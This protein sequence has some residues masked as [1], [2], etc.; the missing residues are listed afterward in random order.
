[1]CALATVLLA[2]STAV[3]QTNADPIARCRDAHV[4][5]P[6]GHIECLEEAL[7]GRGASP[8]TRA[9]PSA[10][11]DGAAIP[12]TIPTAPAP[13]A[14]TAAR[15]Q[16]IPTGLG[17]EQVPA[18]QPAPASPAEQVATVRISSTH[19]NAAGLGVF[20]MADGQVWQET[21]RAPLRLRLEPGREYVA[22]IERGKIAGYRLYVDGANWMYKVKR[23]R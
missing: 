14:E 20:T 11:P 22:R 8:P 7:R 12:R 21:E 2:L 10:S 23:L 17:A 4:G 1:M 13:E 3:S 5:D 16:P 18:L 6:A 19:Y 9:S 15:S